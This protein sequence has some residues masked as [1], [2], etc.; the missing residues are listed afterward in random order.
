MS[1]NA[2]AKPS[3]ALPSCEVSES[4]ALERSNREIMMQEGFQ[5]LYNA[6]KSSV[7]FSSSGKIINAELGI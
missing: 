7:M 2:D 6:S 4:P 1:I 3:N 5:M